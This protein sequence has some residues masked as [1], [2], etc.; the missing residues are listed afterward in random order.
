MIYL[1]W[2]KVEYLGE[3]GYIGANSGRCSFAVVTSSPSWVCKDLE[4]GS[5]FNGRHAITVGIYMKKAQNF[6]DD[7]AFRET[8]TRAMY[9]YC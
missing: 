2:G 4:I 7:S 9:G 8:T 6:T 5:G 1:R 3:G